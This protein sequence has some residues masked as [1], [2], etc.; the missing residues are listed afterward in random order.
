MDLSL[1]IPCYNEEE[2]I[3]LFYKETECIISQLKEK[4]YIQ[5]YEYIFV[6]DGSKD[7]TLSLIKSLAQEN[8]SVH[9]ISFSRNFGKESA[10]YAGIKASKGK[11][12]TIMDADLQDP[13]HLLPTML[14][15]IINEGY[16]SVATRR[17]SRKG[18]PFLRSF[19]ARCFYKLMNKICKTELISGA[20][21][22]R[23]MNRKFVNAILSMS[24]YNRFSK[25]MFGWVG[26]K[27]KWIDFENV[28]RAAGKTKWSFW[29]LFKYAIEG[30]V[31]F[32]EKPLVIS[33]VAGIIVTVLSLIALLFIVIRRLVYGDP[34]QGWASTIC[35]IL[36]LGGQQMLFTGILG[37]Y[38]A[39]TYLEVKNRPIFICS[40]TN[41]ETIMGEK[42]AE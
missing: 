42:D 7:K 16:D 30:I 1:I 4:Q 27:T 22:Y 41:I 40:D 34:V 2:V 38:L 18:E 23:L 11:Y 17:S 10:M 19:F 13:P 3:Y 9:Y 8:K 29:K 15:A 28:E 21:D 33:A 31:T 12:V 6:D 5:S 35:I 20:R 37:E 36:F 32:T 25:G 24:E 14:N 26:F 39:K